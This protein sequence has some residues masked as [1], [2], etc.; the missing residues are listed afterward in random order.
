LVLLGHLHFFSGGEPAQDF[1]P[2]LRDFLH[3]R[4]FHGGRILHHAAHNK[5]AKTASLRCVMMVTWKTEYG[6]G[7]RAT[8]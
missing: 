4:G 8:V 1:G 3:T 7:N 2:L 6:S 5:S